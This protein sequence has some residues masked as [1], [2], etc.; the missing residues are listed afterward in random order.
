VRGTNNPAKIALDILVLHLQHSIV[1][2][3]EHHGATPVAQ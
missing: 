3:T 2:S 1:C